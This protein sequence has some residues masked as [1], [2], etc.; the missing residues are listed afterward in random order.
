MNKKK[1]CIRCGADNP[2]LDLDWH[3][4]TC[5]RELLAENKRLKAEIEKMENAVHRMNA[6]ATT[7]VWGWFCSEMEKE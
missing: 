6:N 4:S 5:Y 2:S 3:C 7:D 1:I